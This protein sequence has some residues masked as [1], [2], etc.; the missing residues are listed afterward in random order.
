MPIPSAEGVGRAIVEERRD[1]VDRGSND[2]VDERKPAV[3]KSFEKPLFGA[4]YLVAVH[5]SSITLP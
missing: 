5:I 4:I 3:A 2:D 1:V